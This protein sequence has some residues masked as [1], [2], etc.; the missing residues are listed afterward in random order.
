MFVSL[1]VELEVGLELGA[2]AAELT[3]VG[4][5]GYLLPFSLWEAPANAAVVKQQLQAV[6]AESLAHQAAEHLQGRAVIRGWRRGQAIGRGAQELT[7]RQMGLRGEA[8]R[9]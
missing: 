8:A 1:E 5:A 7:W 2:V 4:V 3:A 6:C 9:G